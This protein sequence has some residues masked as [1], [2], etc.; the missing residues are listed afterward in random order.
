VCRANESEVAPIFENHN[1]LAVGIRTV[2]LLDDKFV[3]IRRLCAAVNHGRNNVSSRGE[4]KMNIVSSLFHVSCCKFHP[5]VREPLPVSWSSLS[6]NLRIIRSSSLNVL[7][8][9]SS[10]C[11]TLHNNVLFTTF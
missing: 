7:I 5:P 4:I 1:V 2:L 9:V 3:S 6:F 8:V 10:L 11:T